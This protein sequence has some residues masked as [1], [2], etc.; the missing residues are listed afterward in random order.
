M[1]YYEYDHQPIGP[2]DETTLSQ[3][4]REG[5]ITVLTLVWQE[6]ME[7]WKHLGETR[8][9]D[10]ARSA[11]ARPTPTSLPT[12]GMPMPSAVPGT[13]YGA[14][15]TIPSGVAVRRVKPA[16]L[17]HL[18]NWWR[19]LLFIMMGYEL[20]TLFFPTSSVVSTLS[21]IDLIVGAAEI[22]LTFILLYQFWK[23]IQDEQTFTTPGKAVGFLF[24]PFFSYYWIFRAVGSLTVEQNR[25]IERHLAN[26][27]GPE[28]RKAHPLLSYTSVIVGLIVSIGEYVYLIVKMGSM[29]DFNMTTYSNLMAPLLTPITL[30]SL[31]ILLLAF[32][33]FNDFYSTSQSILDSS[34]RVQ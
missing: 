7:D 22:V 33:T 13:P 23:V 24:I 12:G 32:L 21:C 27:P 30:V 9:N 25:F 2:V 34:T 26:Q 5:K 14:F 17:R 16:R 11:E 28:V 19:S 4:L 18:F 1:W 6:G 10:L 31:G 3:L 29:G 8:L 20:L 15:P